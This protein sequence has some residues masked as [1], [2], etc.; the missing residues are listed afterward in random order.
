MQGPRQA[1]SGLD[2]GPRSSAWGTVSK[3]KAKTSHIW[4]KGC[5]VLPPPLAACGRH[6][7]HIRNMKRERYEARALGWHVVRIDP[8]GTESTIEVW[9]EEKAKHR[10][11]VLDQGAAESFEAK[12]KLPR[13]GRDG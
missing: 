13:K 12:Q 11:A 1:S 8:N 9:P 2:V 6:G 3:I 4:A 7:A 10:A 5:R